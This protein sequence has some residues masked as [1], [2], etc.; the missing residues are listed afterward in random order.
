MQT[1]VWFMEDVLYAKSNQNNDDP[2]A[3]V[4][5]PTPVIKPTKAKAKG[6]HYFITTCEEAYKEKLAKEKE[7]KKKE[8]LNEE[9]RERW[10]RFLNED[11]I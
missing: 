2:D 8:M 9:R 3:D 7:K 10:L 5:P 11:G 6:Q 1:H 4:L